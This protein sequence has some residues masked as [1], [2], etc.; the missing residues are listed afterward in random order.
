MVLDVR[1]LG[2]GVHV[3]NYDFARNVTVVGT[4][5]YLNSA[6]KQ[7]IEAHVDE[8]DFVCIE[9]DKIRDNDTKATDLG[10]TKYLHSAGFDP[11][12]LEGDHLYANLGDIFLYGSLQ[13]QV[14]QV[15]AQNARQNHGVAISSTSE[16]NEFLFIQELCEAHG[17]PCYFVD[18]IESHTR[19]RVMMM[20]KTMGIA[21]AFLDEAMDRSAYMEAE[22]ARICSERFAQTG[23]NEQCVLFVGSGHLKDFPGERFKKA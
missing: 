2:E 6:E 14:R 16:G 8:A 21:R 17:K 22:V 7:R 12:R 10:R 3:E 18:K 9:W 11:T 13:E 15:V 1:N 20:A 19:Y 4:H 23:I 5:H